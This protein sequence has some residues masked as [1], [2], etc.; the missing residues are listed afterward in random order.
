MVHWAKFFI[1][2]QETINHRFIMKDPSYGAYFFG[3]KVDVANSVHPFSKSLG[4]DP[5]PVC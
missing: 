1:E 2:A 5:V 3:G 4:L